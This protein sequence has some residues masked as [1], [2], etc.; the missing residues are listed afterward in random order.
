[1][2]SPHHGGDICQYCPVNITET[3]TAFPPAVQKAARESV[4]HILLHRLCVMYRPPQNLAKSESLLCSAA[5]LPEDSPLAVRRSAVF[6][7]KDESGESL[8]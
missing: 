1:M 6:D 7:G 3:I 5:L 4:P 8:P 2:F